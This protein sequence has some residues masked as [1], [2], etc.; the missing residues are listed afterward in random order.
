M[1]QLR[2]ELRDEAVKQL[3]AT[4]HFCLR[5]PMRIEAPRVPRGILQQ[6]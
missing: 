4:R 1:I 5:T 6:Q 3:R 2:V